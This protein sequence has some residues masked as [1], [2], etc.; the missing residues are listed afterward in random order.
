ML[1]VNHCCAF[2]I[3]EAWPIQNSGRSIHGTDSH[4]VHVFSKL[5]FFQKEDKKETLVNHLHVNIVHMYCIS[6]YIS[7][8]AAHMNSFKEALVLPCSCTEVTQCFPVQTM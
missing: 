4:V 8:C 2:Q 3:T 5:Y 7:R 1:A 6:K